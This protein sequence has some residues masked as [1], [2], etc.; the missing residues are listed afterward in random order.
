[1]REMYMNAIYTSLLPYEYYRGQ[2][3]KYNSLIND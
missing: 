1:M 3:Q 2:N